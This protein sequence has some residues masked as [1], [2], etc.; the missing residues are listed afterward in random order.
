MCNFF[1]IIFFEATVRAEPSVLVASKIL[2]KGGCGRPFYSPDSLGIIN[3]R[4]PKNVLTSSHQ[5]IG[6]SPDLC[7]KARWLYS[8]RH[9]VLYFNKIHP[10]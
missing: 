3:A 6:P 4:V 2:R 7:N 9:F 8:L 10:A 5:L 1:I